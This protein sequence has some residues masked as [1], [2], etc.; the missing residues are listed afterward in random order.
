VSASEAVPVPESLFLSRKHLQDKE[1][2]LA[3]QRDEQA[4]DATTD[5]KQLLG[6]LC[7]DRHYGCMRKE[8]LKLNAM[9]AAQGIH[10]TPGYA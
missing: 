8:Q 4:A 10:L 3:N 5:C 7:A 9:F 2:L 6:A 1:T